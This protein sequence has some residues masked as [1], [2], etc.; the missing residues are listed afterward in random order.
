MGVTL[1]SG[2][3]VLATAVLAGCSSGPSPKPSE[4]P[5]QAVAPP[6]GAVP[7]EIP[8]PNPQTGFTQIVA[9]AADSVGAIP[10]SATAQYAYRF[11]QTLPGSNTFT[12]QDRDLSFYFRPTP[13]ALHFQVENRQSRPVTIVWDRTTWIDNDGTEKAAHA[14]STWE[15]RYSP[16]AT[17]QILGLQ[18]YSDYVFPMSYLVDPGTSNQQLHRVLFPEDQRAVQFADRDFGVDFTFDIDNRMVPYSFRFKVAS[19]VPR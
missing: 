14:T 3:A 18:R 6:P 4:A 9:G 16:Q 17:T 1:R 15:G 10:G 13:G 2:L 19:V 12:F 8:K 7:A 5:P 11:R